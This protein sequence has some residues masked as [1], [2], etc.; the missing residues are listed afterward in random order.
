MTRYVLDLLGVAVIA[1]VTAVG[2]GT[3]RDLLLNR[4]PI[5]WIANPVYL[6]VILA[7]TSVTL[8]YVRLTAEIPLVLRPGLLYATP[9]VAGAG[10]YLGLTQLG[11]PKDLAALAGM[12]AIVGL[13]LGAILRG[14]SLPMVTVPQDDTDL[15]P[16]ASGR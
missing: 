8:A 5:F 4:H 1:V 2:G 9:A 15:P 14:W 7:A 10:L 6:W 3:L 13:R 12:A 11:T 16:A